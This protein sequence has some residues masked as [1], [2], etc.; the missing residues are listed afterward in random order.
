MVDLLST[1]FGPRLVHH[2]KISLR[3]QQFL[4]GERN[5]VGARSGPGP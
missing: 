2:S 5:Y 1:M 3:I 4:E